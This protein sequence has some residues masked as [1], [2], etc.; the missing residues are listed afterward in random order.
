MLL[1]VGLMVVT[2]VVT[3]LIPAIRA[4]RLAVVDALQSARR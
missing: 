1:G 3:G 2:G 4:Q